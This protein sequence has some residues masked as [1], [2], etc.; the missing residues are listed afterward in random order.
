MLWLYVLFTLLGKRGVTGGVW[1]AKEPGVSTFSGVGT[2]NVVV[3]NESIFNPLIKLDVCVVYVVYN[4]LREVS[5]KSLGVL[6]IISE[7]ISH[8]DMKVMNVNDRNLWTNKTM[9]A[10]VL[11]P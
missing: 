9:G 4:S 10:P 2:I 11:E 1:V 6:T 5:V 8:G 3:P 7:D